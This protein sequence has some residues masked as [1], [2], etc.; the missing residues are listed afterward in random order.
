VAGLVAATL[1]VVTA[2]AAS[3][4]PQQVA[5]GGTVTGYARLTRD[6]SCTGDGVALTGDATLD[7]DGHR[8]AGSGT[9]VGVTTSPT[10][11]STIVGGTLRGW[12]RAV[13]GGPDSGESPVVVVRG[14]RFVDNAAA[15]IEA[16]ATTVTV[17]RALVSG[18][19]RGL[20][21]SL[22]ASLT[23]SRSTF[24]GVRFAVTAFQGGMSLT[25][26]SLTGNGIAVNCGDATCDVAGNVLARN[27][28]AVNSFNAATTLADN[29]ITGNDV[30]YTTSIS[31]DEVHGNRFTGNGTAAQVG[32]LGRTVLR[33]NVFVRND[34]GFTTSDVTETAQ[35]ILDRNTFHRNGDGVLV[36]VPGASLSGNSAIRNTRWGIYA[37][38]AIDL[39][40]NTARGNGNQPQ[41]VGVTCHAP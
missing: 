25:G 40:G 38:G 6:L 15:V 19:E 31:V 1:M 8:F 27:D 3:A 32:E 21:A 9:G 36:T 16:F 5:C 37:P 41:C 7:L 23:V 2:G 13:E 39:G 30:G 22:G 11:I 28:T 33:E 18:G 12:D 4:A 24:R 10:G 29:A 14:V 35:V 26:S 17:D 34:V 20:H